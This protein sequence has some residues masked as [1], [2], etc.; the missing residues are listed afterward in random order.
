MQIQNNH[1]Q[2]DHWT[3]GN[4]HSQHLSIP[5]YTFKYL[6]KVALKNRIVLHIRPV[7]GIGF[8]FNL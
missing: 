3:K 1:I 2:N 6:K 5:P 8:A 4:L 7:R